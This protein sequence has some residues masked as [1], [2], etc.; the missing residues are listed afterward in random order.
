MRYENGIEI[1]VGDHVIV[2]G[3]IKGLVVCDFDKRLSLDGYE[4]WLTKKELIGGGT[5]SSGLMIKTSELG[6]LHYPE[7]D[8]IRPDTNSPTD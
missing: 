2:E 3:H 8:D 7:N 4:D 6:F 5:L 1:L